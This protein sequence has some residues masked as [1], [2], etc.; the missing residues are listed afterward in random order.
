MRTAL[1][2]E[3]PDVACK[4]A[5]EAKDRDEAGPRDGKAAE[6]P[7]TVPE[8]A[9]ARADPAPTQLLAVVV[10][11]VTV[12][13]LLAEFCMAAKDRCAAAAALFRN[14][15]DA[16]PSILLL[17]PPRVG[18]L[19]SVTAPTFLLWTPTLCMVVDPDVQ[20]TRN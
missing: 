8:E 3:P 5:D 10:V 9:T 11:V 4:N 20:P 12:V 17:S 18:K 6:S 13:A 15:D 2:E 16:A 19:S 7:G 14:D 1:A